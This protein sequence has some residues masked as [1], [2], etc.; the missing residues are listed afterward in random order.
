MPTNGLRA[1]TN[2]VPAPRCSQPIRQLTV[3]Q[4]VSQP[5]L[6]AVSAVVQKNL[7][8]LRAGFRLKS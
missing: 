2:R 6:L 5:A 7:V 8:S 1:G 4:R 3:P